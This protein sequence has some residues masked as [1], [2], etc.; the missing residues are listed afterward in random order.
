MT[1][2]KEVAAIVQPKEIA[3]YKTKIT[4]VQREAEAYTIVSQTD[5]DH[6]A[7][8]LHVIAG[9]EK[10]ITQRKEEI[11][12]PLMTAL[13]SARD[14]F[15]PL[16]VAHAEAKKVIKGK[17]LEFQIQEEERIAKEQ[18]RI[19]ARVEKGTMKGETAIAKLENLGE[20]PL[21]AS[22]SVGKIQ[23]RTLVKVRVVDESLI[24][25]EYLVP[26]MTKI[27]EAVLRKGIVIPG[28]ERYEEKTIASVSR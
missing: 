6:G 18:A 11:T 14:L 22:G 27:A 8:L 23:T 24:P 19:A 10:S 4:S 15:K 20:A 12:R 17:M 16:E 21:S 26:D 3:L 25:R 2:I 7:D 9:I 13:A 1:K 5:M 28:V